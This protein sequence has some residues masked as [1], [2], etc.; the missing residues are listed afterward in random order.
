MQSGLCGEGHGDAKQPASSLQVLCPPV[1]LLGVCLL[2]KKEN[3]VTQET[4]LEK[5]GSWRSLSAWPRLPPHAR[6]AVGLWVLC[7]QR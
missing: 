7:V 5:R 6:L 3:K 4:K 1:P 2:S